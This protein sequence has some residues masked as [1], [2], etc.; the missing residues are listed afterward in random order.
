MSENGEIY[1]AGKN[2]SLPP[3]LTGWTNSTSDIGF[4]MNI[5]FCFCCY[6]Q[7]GG[8]VISFIISLP[9]TTSE[10]AIRAR[11]SLEGFSSRQPS[12]V[13]KN[14]ADIASRAQ[15]YTVLVRSS[16]S[17]SESKDCSIL[18][19]SSLEICSIVLM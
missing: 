18:S 10:A 4:C 8:L 1:T 15:K 19:A 3:A 7:M 16:I 13:S 14:I 5:L 2:F 11:Q 6:L 12:L 9:R 17:R